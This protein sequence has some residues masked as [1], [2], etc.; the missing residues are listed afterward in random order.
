MKVA[1]R[2]I[3]LVEWPEEDQCYAGSSPGFIGSCCHE[4]DDAKVY[5][6]LCGIVNEWMDIH[7]KENFLCQNHL[8]TNHFQGN[9]LFVQEKIFIKLLLFKAALSG[10]YLN[11]TCTDLLRSSIVR[12]D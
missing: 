4:S 9:L 3:K 12:K 2:Y 5:K 11:K 7:Q 8:R 10:E 1:D 6:Q